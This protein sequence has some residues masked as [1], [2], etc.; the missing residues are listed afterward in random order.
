MGPPNYQIYMFRQG[1]EAVAIDADVE[2]R[3]CAPAAQAHMVRRH[4]EGVR[5]GH[6]QGDRGAD[7]EQTGAQQPPVSASGTQHTELAPL[8]IAG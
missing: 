8:G 1:D 5:C 6:Q 3:G 2:L 7:H 4:A